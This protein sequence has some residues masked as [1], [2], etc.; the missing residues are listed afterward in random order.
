MVEEALLY[1]QM[2]GELSKDIDCKD[3]AQTLVQMS[4][5]FIFNWCTTNGGIDLI[6]SVQ[7]MAKLYLDSIKSNEG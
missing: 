2:N 6:N 4:R 5:G 3:A 1:G 7:S